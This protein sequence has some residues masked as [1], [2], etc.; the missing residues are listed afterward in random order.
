M[1]DVLYLVLSAQRQLEVLLCVR[2]KVPG[3]N[4]AILCGHCGIAFGSCAVLVCSRCAM[5]YHVSS[6]SVYFIS[7]SVSTAISFPLVTLTLTL[8]CDFCSRTGLAV[9]WGGHVL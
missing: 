3:K 5:K 6:L 7:P 9:W 1:S 4:I 8:R 2:C